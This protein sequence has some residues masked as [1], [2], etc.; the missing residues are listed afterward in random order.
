MMGCDI[1]ILAEARWD[2]GCHWRLQL[3]ALPD[4]R[5]YEAFS[6]LGLENRGQQEAI[7]PLRG[8]PRDL[9]AAAQAYIRE[10]DIWDHSPSWLTLRELL[11]YDSPETYLLPLL[12]KALRSVEEHNPEDVRI[13]FAFDN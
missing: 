13:V 5:D 9:S 1:H 6:V 8:Y 7:V 10:S 12:I 3:L 2:K 4:D 11:D